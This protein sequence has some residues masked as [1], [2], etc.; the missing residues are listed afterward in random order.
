MEDNRRWIPVAALAPVLWGTTYYV[1]RH[2]LP[3]DSPLWGGVLRALPAG[4]VL[5]ALARRLP[6][7]AWWWRSAVLGTL[8]T[9][10]FFALVYVAAQTLPTSIASTVMA[11]GPVA[12]MLAAWVLLGQRPRLRA[13]VGGVLGVVGVAV[14]LLGGGDGAGLD[15]AGIAASVAAMLLS[16]VG[17]VLATRW[18]GEVEVLPLTA[19]QLV[20]GALV[21]LPVAAVVEGAPPALDG[22]ALLGFA[23]VSLV[24]TA[25]ANV[26]WF[27]ALRHLGPTPVGL[28][29]L[30]NPVTGVLL[31]TVVAAE[32]LSGRQVVGIAVVLAAMVLGATGRR[33]PAVPAPPARTGPLTTP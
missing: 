22:R 14:M 21:L 8:T 5:L 18:Q 6:R 32:T 10:A 15:P 29:G 24:A 30:L 31:G 27:A 3:A 26:A 2:T 4:L 7:G 11:V 13:V 25:V 12:M 1:T 20:G 33:R 17:Y 28:V 9:G 16:S 23:Y 19:W